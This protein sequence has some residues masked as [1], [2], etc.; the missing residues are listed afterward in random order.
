MDNLPN[1]IFTCVIGVKAPSWYGMDV[2]LW[3][4][5]AITEF[6]PEHGSELPWFN[7]K[8]INRAERSFPPHEE[9]SIS[10]SRRPDVSQ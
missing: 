9:L 5:R 3:N 10:F 2:D 1:V 6:V 8:L 4:S 7:S